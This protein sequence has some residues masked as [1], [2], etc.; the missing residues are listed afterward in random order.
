M[1]EWAC[2]VFRAQTKT[3]KAKG[4][5]IGIF[6]Q[7]GG[8]IFLVEIHTF[9]I[10]GQLFIFQ[11]LI[12]LKSGGIIGAAWQVGLWLHIV[13]RHH[14]TAR[15]RMGSFSRKLICGLRVSLPRTFEALRDLFQKTE[16]QVIGC[17]NFYKCD[18]SELSDFKILMPD[19]NALFKN[20][21]EIFRTRLFFMS[22]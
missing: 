18:K 5:K 16:Q 22:I 13:A 9:L 15:S 14:S 6:L 12:V 4:S 20:W 7:Y 1:A 2:T 8:T 11:L 10:W 19:F 21:L 3:K 17:R